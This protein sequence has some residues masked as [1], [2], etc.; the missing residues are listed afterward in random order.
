[1]QTKTIL[2]TGG[3]TR[4]GNIIAQYFAKKNYNLAIHYNTS[5]NNAQKLVHELSSIGAASKKERNNTVSLNPQSKTKQK[6]KAYQADLLDPLS[7]KNL[8]NNVMNDFSSIDILIN[9]ASIYEKISFLDTNYQAITENFNLHLMAPFFLIQNFAKLHNKGHVINITDTRITKNKTGYFPYLLSKKSLSNLTSMLATELAPEIKVNEICPG[10]ILPSKDSNADISD[11][12]L[13]A[14]L[15]N[16][17]IAN[18]NQI[19]EAINFIIKNN[20]IGQK[21]FIDGGEHLL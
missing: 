11:D 19:I 2:I 15:P 8:I 13:K 9:N 16:K 3:A 12:V 6:I 21:F 1:M 10:K 17:D 14:K 7:S 20:P 5:G 4:L 18:T